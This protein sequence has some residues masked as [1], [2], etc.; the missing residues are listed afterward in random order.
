MLTSWLKLSSDLFFANLDAQ[1]VITLRL[2]KL[3][4]GGKAA[5][6]ESRL[7]VT[8]K[9]NAA[10]EAAIALACEKTPQSV[11]KRYRT[12]MRSNTRRLTRK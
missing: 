12:I 5:E 6:T 3:A 2:A 8:E 1:R 7:M 9:V 11:V 4:K 10:A